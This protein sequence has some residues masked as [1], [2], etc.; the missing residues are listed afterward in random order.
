LGSSVLRLDAFGDTPD[1]P[2]FLA[3]SRFFAAND[4]IALRYGRAPAHADELLKNPPMI[5]LQAVA[6]ILGDE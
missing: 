2:R 4:Y 5:G 1:T 6:Y 3:P